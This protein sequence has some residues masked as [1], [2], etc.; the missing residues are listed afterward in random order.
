MSTILIKNGLLFDGLGSE[1]FPGSV[2][3]VDDKIAKIGTDIEADADQIIHA[4]GMAITPG[5]IDI[6]RHCDIMPFYSDSFSAC[7]LAQGITTTV[8]GNCGI[9]MTPVS[10]NPVTAREMHNFNEP[11]LGPFRAGHISTFPEYLSALDNAQLFLNFASLIGTGSVKIAAKGFSNTPFTDDEMNTASDMIREALAEGA[12]G[13]SVGIMYIPECYSST[14][15]YIRLLKPVGIYGGIVTAHI[16]DEGDTL[17]ASIK[18]M[19]EIGK[20]INCAIEISHFKSIYKNNWHKEIYQAI[21]LIEQ[22]RADGLDITCDFYPYDCGSTALTTIIPPDFVAGDMG[23]A[24]RLLGTPK[25]VDEY[26][27]LGAAY[28]GSWERFEEILGWNRIIISGV[29]KDHNRKYIG[30]SVDAAAAEY[31]FQDSC[32]FVAYLIHDEDGKTAIINRTMCQEDIDAVAKL[33]YSIVISDSIYAQTD[34]PHPRM[35]GAFPKIIREYVYERGLITLPEAIYKMTGAPAQRMRIDRR[36]QLKEGFY[37]DIN[38]FRPEEFRDNATF[39]APTKLASGLGYSIVNGN[40]AWKSNKVEPGFFGR[41][42]RIKNK[43]KLI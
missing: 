27:R 5:F 15:E 8:V 2:L 12:A 23:G 31:G 19:I 18:E 39:D 38:I 30:K 4:D 26:R 20:Q 1:P 16:R 14:E 40:I 25:G 9:S 35:Y 41:N 7:M 6:H 21:E 11:V 24:I 32:A 34:T 17:T 10:Q 13:V 28:Y 37:A 3:L 29:V 42:L 22:A 36:G 43:P 33:P